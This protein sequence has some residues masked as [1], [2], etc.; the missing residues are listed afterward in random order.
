MKIND[1][2]AHAIARSSG[3][4]A[5]LPVKHIPPGNEIREH[6]Q[7]IQKPFSIKYTAPHLTFPPLL[8]IT[9][10]MYT[11]AQKSKARGVRLHGH[12]LSGA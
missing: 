1:W 3:A 10:Y 7:Y 12:E 8:S 2:Q 11:H 9:L 5:S 6:T 4:P